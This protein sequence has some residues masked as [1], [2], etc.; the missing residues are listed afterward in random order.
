MMC[1]LPHND[2]PGTTFMAMFLLPFSSEMRDNLIAKRIEKDCTCTLYSTLMAEYA[3]LVH[4]SWSSCSIATVHKEYEVAI[5]TVS[6]SHCR[7]F[8]L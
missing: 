6:G 2:R 1:L 5:N 3:D 8:S 4:N 7:D